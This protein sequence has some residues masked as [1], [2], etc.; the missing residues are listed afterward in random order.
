MVFGSRFLRNNRGVWHARIANRLLTTDQRAVPVVADDMETRK[1]FRRDVLGKLR[2]RAVG[3]DF[4]PEFTAKVILAGWRIVEV[5]ITYRPRRVDEGK[6]IR[7]VDGL[8][9]I[10]MLLKCRLFER[11]P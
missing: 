6:K 9:A 7:W 2:L 4:E 10:Y 5:P 8:D 11:R 1:L 3:F